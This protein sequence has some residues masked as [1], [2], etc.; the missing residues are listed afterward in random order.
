MT[1]LIRAM[2]SP[3]FEARNRAHGSRRQSFW[4]GKRG[5]AG[6]RLDCQ[7]RI[8]RIESIPGIARWASLLLKEKLICLLVYEMK[9]IHEVI[10][11]LA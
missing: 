4:T 9:S 3:L 5:S 6:L 11:V 1:C 8:W 10:I 7:R 2:R